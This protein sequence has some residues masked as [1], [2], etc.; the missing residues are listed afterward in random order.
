VSPGVEVRASLLLD[1][2]AVAVVR[3]F[4][5]EEAA[6]RAAE[7]VGGEGAEHVTR[8]MGS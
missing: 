3:Q 2:L 5:R 1:C 8:A 6:S 4:L 7:R